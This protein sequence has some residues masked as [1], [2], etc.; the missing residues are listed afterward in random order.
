MRGPA[1]KF[2]IVCHNVVTQNPH[3]CKAEKSRPKTDTI[4]PLAG[5][6]PTPKW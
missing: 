2:C 3:V 5:W 6:R 4:R 1:A